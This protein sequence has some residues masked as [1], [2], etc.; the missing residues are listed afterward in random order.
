M[1]YVNGRDAGMSATYFRQNRSAAATRR[2]RC[3]RTSI[4]RHE[5]RSARPCNR[6]RFFAAVAKIRAN[7]ALA[8]GRIIADFVRATM[9]VVVVDGC[10]CCT[11]IVLNRIVLR[12]RKALEA[13]KR[14]CIYGQDSLRFFCQLVNLSKYPLGSWMRNSI[15][16]SAIPSTR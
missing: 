5:S 11:V 13:I 12:E 3:G 15:C 14:R 2:V 6:W 7:A 4:C 1:V 16:S 8:T 10:R 9:P